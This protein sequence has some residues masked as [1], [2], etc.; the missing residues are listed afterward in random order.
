MASRYEEGRGRRDLEI[1]K[2]NRQI[3]RMRPGQT[4]R[5]LGLAPFRLRF[6]LDG[7]KSVGDREAV[8]LPAAGCGH[9]DLFIP[10]SQEAP[11]AFTFFWTASHRWEGK[12]FS[13]EMERG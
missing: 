2:F 13:V 3:R 4:L 7:W 10:Q 8:F 6:S 9:V 5:L 11:V 12:D 1:W